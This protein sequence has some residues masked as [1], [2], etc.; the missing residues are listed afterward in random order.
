MDR[1]LPFNIAKYEIRLC[2]GPERGVRGVGPTPVSWQGPGKTK[3][4]KL[5]KFYAISHK[6]KKKIDFGVKD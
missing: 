1:G 2:A 5:F 3:F 4:W 6:T